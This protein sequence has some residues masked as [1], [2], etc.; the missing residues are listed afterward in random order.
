MKQTTFLYGFMCLC[1]SFNL[2]ADYTAGGDI[3]GTYSLTDTE[4]EYLCRFEFPTSYDGSNNKVYDLSDYNNDA[5][6]HNSINALSDDIPDGKTGKSFDCSMGNYF[7]T[8]NKNILSNEL[9]NLHGGF[10]FDTWFKWNGT[11]QSSRQELLP[12]LLLNILP[13]KDPVQTPT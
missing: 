1:I 5:T 6:T 10:C 3:N 2:S 9:I 7:D 12:I 13:L 4:P 8:D 11:Y